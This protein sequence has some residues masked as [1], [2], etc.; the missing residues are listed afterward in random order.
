MQRSELYTHTS[1]HVLHI[2]VVIVPLKSLQLF[3]I[4][5]TVRV[6]IIKECQ[7]LKLSHMTVQFL[8]FNLVAQFI[9]L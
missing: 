3:V 5:N 1:T 7:Q 8:N 2:H 4:F 9:E 6:N